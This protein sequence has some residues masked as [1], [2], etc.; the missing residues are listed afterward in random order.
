MQPQTCAD[1][2]EVPRGEVMD[3]AALELKGTG[4]VDGWH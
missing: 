3:A 2:V 1:A 4:T